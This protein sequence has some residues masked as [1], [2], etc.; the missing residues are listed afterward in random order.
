MTYARAR[1]AN[2]S[3]LTALASA[4]IT[5]SSAMTYFPGSNSLSDARYLVWKPAGNF[6]A[7]ATNNLIYINDGSNKTATITAGSYTYATMAT[8]VATALNAVSSTWTCTYSTTTRSFTIGHTGSATLRETQTTNSAWD[9][10]GYTNGTDHAGTSFVADVSRNHTHES[11]TWD[12]GS[13][14]AGDFFACIGQINADFPISDQATITLK[15]NSVNSFTAPPFSVTLTRTTDGI[16]RFND[17]VSS[18]SYRYWE[19]KFIDR[20]NTLGPEGFPISHFYIGDY[21]TLTSTNVAIGFDKNLVDLTTKST[22]EAGSNFYKT[23]AKRWEFENCKIQQMTEAE[24]LVYQT[25]FAL[26]GTHTPFYFSL[27]PL[28]GVSTTIN[29]LTKFVNFERSPT[30]NNIIR[31]IYTMAFNLREVV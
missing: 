13:A 1:F 4:N 30:F 22:S 3:Q 6:T 26:Y 18:P 29:D 19:F 27:D 2:N 10:L 14:K 25:F 23:Q 24:R 7:D 9:I 28:I 31:D 21:D 16:F 8:A 15:A 20:T 5:Y 17:A 12:L 11:V